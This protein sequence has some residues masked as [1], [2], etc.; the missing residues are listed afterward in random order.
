MVFDKE[1]RSRIRDFFSFSKQ[2]II[3]L[4]VALLV[5]GFIFSFRDWGLE[6]L[7]LTLGLRNLI[8]VSFVAAISFFLRISMQ[9]IYALSEGYKTEF[10]VWWT[11]IVIAL[12]IAFVSNGRIP[13]VLIGA[14]VSS[15]M[16][17]QRLGEFRY[18]FSHS[19]NATIALWGI[20]GS[21]ITATL[22]ALGLHFSPQ[23]YFFSK[24]VLLNLI[25]ALCALLP[26]PQ[27]EGLQIYF[28][29]RI[30][31]VSGIVAVILAGFLLLTKT[32]IG[33]VITIIVSASL[34]IAFLLKS[35][36]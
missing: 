22:F 17:K 35:G 4:A 32:A 33:L 26:L 27:L 2:E 36:D 34:G 31:Y 30:Q 21:L 15:F 3:G 6:T 20:L 16:I 18:G 7:D 8:I 1:L 25:M 14:S 13:L 23:S 5:T 10:K 29:S 24:G 28:G 19:D 12:V 11:G 9:K